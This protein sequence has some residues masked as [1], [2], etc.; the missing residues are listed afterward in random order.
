MPLLV[1]QLA[2]MDELVFSSLGLPHL[3]LHSAMRYS[4]N[5]T[6]A[7]LLVEAIPVTQ[8]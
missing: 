5:L 2:E 4:I 3:Q 6:M 7:S 1:L 8:T